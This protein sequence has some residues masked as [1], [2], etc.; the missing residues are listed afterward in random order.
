[1]PV[2]EVV[3]IAPRHV[4]G[5][6]AC[7]RAVFA[8]DVSGVKGAA[9]F[10]LLDAELSRTSSGFVIAGESRIAPFAKP[11]GTPGMALRAH[12]DHCRGVKSHFDEATQWAFRDRDAD[13]AG[14]LPCHKPRRSRQVGGQPVAVLR[15]QMPLDG[16]HFGIADAF[17]AGEIRVAAQT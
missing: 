2:T 10:V 11:A 12:F 6:I 1:M 15:A 13:I 14:A 7:G 17:G 5:C 4:I 8:A 3:S 9:R 16:S